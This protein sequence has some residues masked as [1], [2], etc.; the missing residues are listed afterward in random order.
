MGGH[1]RRRAPRDC[2]APRTTADCARRGTFGCV[3]VLCSH[4]FVTRGTTAYCEVVITSRIAIVGVSC[5]LPGG[6]DS[7]NRLA[8]A[9]ADGADLVGPAPADRFDATHFTDPNPERPGKA[10]CTDG[11]YLADIAGFDAEFFGISPREASRMDPQQ[12][13]L[14]EMAREAFDDAGIDPATT[15]GSRTS[16]H[17]GAS[18]FGYGALQQNRPETV[19]A[20]TMTGGAGGNTANRVSH[21]FDLR[22]PSMAVDTA[23]SS[24]L[25]ALHQACEGLRA[26]RVRTALAGGINVL[27]NP[28]DFVGFSKASML[29]P[30]GRCRAFS[31]DADGY[32]RAEGGGILVLKRLEDAQ[33][34]GDRIHALI[35]ATE[36][37]ADGHTR[38]L[39]LPS[40]EAQETLLRD[41]YDRAGLDPDDVAYME[42]H[43]TGTQAGDPVECDALGRAL[44]QR[45]RRDNPLPIG[46]IKSNIGH[47]ESGAGIAGVLKG[48]VVLRDGVIPASLHA[49]TLNP[50]IDF[51]RLGLR[52]VVSARPLP[53]GGGLVGVNS[54]GFG[55]ANAHTV[56]A[57]APEP[58]ARAAVPSTADGPLPLLV[59]GHTAEALAQAA[60]RTAEALGAAT[61]R[62]AFYDLAWTSCRRRGHLSERAAV[63]AA[64]STQAAE[65]LRAIADG[66]PAD[67]AARQR[68]TDPALPVFAYCGNGAQWAGMGAALL[69]AD[70]D[71]RAAVT[72]VDAALKSHLDWS[73]LDALRKPPEEWTLERTEVAQP[74]L[75]AVQAAVTEVLRRRGVRPVAVFGHSVGEVAAAYAAG[76]LDLPSACRVIAERSRV[77]ALTA[78]RGR[79]AAVGLSAEDAAA[80]V[81]GYEGKLEVAG[82]NSGRDATVTGDAQCLAALGEQLRERGV[83]FRD[84]NLDYA[85]HSR[86]MDDQ[87]QPLLKGLEGLAPRPAEIPFVSAVTGSP[88]SGTELDAEY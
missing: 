79:M 86:A 47:L 23:C 81:A 44:G 33:A 41:A 26:G 80:A 31:V 67:G 74:L 88:L 49:E 48:L 56:L 35:A 82:V 51:A 13:L 15:A 28:Y 25:V 68:A 84:L 19:D 30:T 37:N 38:G 39:A 77:Q 64:D 58:A 42:A 46:S 57:P 40:A 17:I 21:A 71:F 12:R 16:V 60:R 45:R 27:L 70:A 34:D 4:R 10:Y 3:S 83:F 59:S 6:I 7:L 8:A 54:F 5:R 53:D 85:F 87:R 73:V 61:S 55:G 11:G 78:G 66:E 50:R 52:P 22:G 2:R 1:C 32:V 69:E 29:S 63:I 24:A 62:Q 65:K 9:L 75:F 72:D 20:H 14:L 76:I 36:A 18:S 43:G